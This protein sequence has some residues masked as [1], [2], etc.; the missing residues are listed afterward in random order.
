MKTN[1]KVSPQQHVAMRLYN[2]K[3]V[4][5]NLKK[6][7]DILQILLYNIG[8]E[9]NTGGFALVIGGYVYESFIVSGRER[10]G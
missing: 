1:K 7:I 10:H 2:N 3:G 6:I 5:A 4:C 9:K 8:V